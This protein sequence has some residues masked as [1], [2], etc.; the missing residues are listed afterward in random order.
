MVP[1]SVTTTSLHF[2]LPDGTVVF[3]DVSV[4]LAGHHVGV[5]GANGAGKTTFVRLLTGEL[6]PT[7]GAIDRPASIALVPQD[8]TVRS[9][10]AID[11]LIGIADVR[12]ALHRIEHGTADDADH[13]ALEGNWDV[14]ERAVALFGQLGLARL[15]ATPTDL[16][17]VVDTLSGGEATLVAVIGAVLASPELLVLDE[18]TNNL[19][20]RARRLLLDA[21]ERF[22]GQV[23]TVSHDRDLLDHVDAVAE[24]RDGDIRVVAGDYAH[25]EA[26]LAA[27]QERAREVLAAARNDEARQRRELTESQTVVAHRQRYGRKMY[28]QKREPKIVMQQRKRAAQESAAKLTGGHRRRLDEAREQASAAA[29]AVRDDRTVRVDLPDTA[30]HPG[31]VVLPPTR[32]TVPAGTVEVGIVGPERIALRGRNGAGKTTLI[33]QLVAAG[34]QVPVG[35]LPQVLDG[36]D[37]DA[38]PYDLVAAVSPDRTAEDRRAGLARLLFRGRDADRPVRELSGGERVRAA[39]A[40]ALLS[41]PAPRLLVLDEPTNNVDITTREHLAQA[42]ADFRGALLVVSHDE[43]FVDALGITREI[44]LDRL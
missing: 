10:V 29:D 38:S 22:D 24:V 31:Q 42:L 13:A 8:I 33:D 17:R 34:P 26:V 14:E 15:V 43:R 23:V 20:P 40:V 27:E 11:E 2:R 41:S 36:L 21:I 3:D 1:R 4:T 44:D 5:V 12:A 25:F 28:A 16:S 18:P 35:V 30:V 37:P 7:S 32:F 9:A 6:A 39:M 19:D